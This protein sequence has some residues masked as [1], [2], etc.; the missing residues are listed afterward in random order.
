MTSLD[1]LHPD[2]DGQHDGVAPLL[3]HPLP[4]LHLQPGLPSAKHN[5][6]ETIQGLLKCKQKAPV[7]S[8]SGSAHF[9]AARFHSHRKSSPPRVRNSGRLVREPPS[10]GELGLAGV[11]HRGREEEE[12]R[13]HIVLLCL[14]PWLASLAKTH[15]TMKVRTFVNIRNRV[16]SVPV[17]SLPQSSMRLIQPGLVP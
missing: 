15:L 7:C 1:L 11:V 10:R 2:Q 12:R 3:A 14:C 9:V 4:L 8:S 16:T 13:L 5:I 6:L 17:R